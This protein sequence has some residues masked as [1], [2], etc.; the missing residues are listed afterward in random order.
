MIQD[1]R[2]SFVRALPVC[3]PPAR[4]DR[5][6]DLTPAESRRP[7]WSRLIAFS[8]NSIQEETTDFRARPEAGDP[9]ARLT[10]YVLNAAIILF[11][12]PVGLATLIFNI[13]GGEN[14]RTTA[15]VMAL[16]GLGMALAASGELPALTTFL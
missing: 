2:Q 15:H 6:P 12:F 7:L 11:V 13:L 3:R 14:L 9:I 16:T 8:H 4:M 10:V 1:P 5:L